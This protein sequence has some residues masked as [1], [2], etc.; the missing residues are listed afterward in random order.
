MRTSF[1]IGSGER[2]QRPLVADP[3]ILGPQEG[4]YQSSYDSTWR[5]QPVYDARFVEEQLDRIDALMDQIHESLIA[6]TREPL[7]DAREI[8]SVASR[9]QQVAQ[10]QESIH[11][12]I[13]PVFTRGNHGGADRFRHHLSRLQ[14]QDDLND[15]L[16]FRNNRL[17][18]MYEQI[19]DRDSLIGRIGTMATISYTFDAVSDVLTVGTGQILR[20]EA[21]D[22]L[23]VTVLG[24]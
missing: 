1:T 21:R 10:I 17:Q 20:H 16:L 13:L 2:Q 4:A 12:I 23:A 19:M 9:M 7:L 11:Q 24:T 5:Q 3:G 8:R 18:R 14:Q 22:Q 6:A 15:Y